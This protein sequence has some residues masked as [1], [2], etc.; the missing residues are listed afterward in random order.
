MSKGKKLTIITDKKGCGAS[1]EVYD[2]HCV[3]NK[4][5]LG[6]SG[7]NACHS[8]SIIENIARNFIVFDN[9]T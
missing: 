2:Q 1:K 3:A 8:W 5:L 7:Y 9:S 4:G 6:A